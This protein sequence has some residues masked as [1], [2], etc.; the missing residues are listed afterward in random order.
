MNITGAFNFVEISPML[1][2][3]GLP[4]IEQIQGLSEHGYEAVI[5]LLPDDS[6]YA[7]VGETAAINEQGLAYHYIPVD[8][9]NPQYTDFVEF[10]AAM[11]AHAGQRL[12][13]HCA[14][15]YRVSVFYALYA[16]LK[17]EWDAERMQKHMHSLMNPADYP[18]WPE[19]IEDV[20]SKGLP[21]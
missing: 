7:V 3:S 5:N 4:T 18:P 1:T 17:G 20:L 16:H 15:N 11:D 2:T 19:F 8:Y 12:H 21:G 13:V 9:A 6:E 14:A 10:V